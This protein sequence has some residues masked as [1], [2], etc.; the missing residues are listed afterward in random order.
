[1]KM[2]GHEAIAD[3]AHWNPLVC[4]THQ[5]DKRGE[6]LVLVKN[7][8]ATIPAIED[9]ID[10]VAFR[11]SRCSCHSFSLKM[12]KAIAKY[13]VTFSYIQTTNSIGQTN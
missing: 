4:L 2:V 8:R 11:R 7:I 10:I 3:Q 5:P 1:M 12:G 13:N 6:V 9:M